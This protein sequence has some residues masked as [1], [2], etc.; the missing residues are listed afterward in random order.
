MSSFRRVD[1]ERKCATTLDACSDVF[2]KHEKTAV[3]LLHSELDRQLQRSWRDGPLAKHWQAPSDEVVSAIE[4]ASGMLT[5]RFAF[6]LT[7]P[8]S[9]SLTLAQKLGECGYRPIRA[10]PFASDDSVFV[11][12]AWDRDGELVEAGSDLTEKEV[13]D[14]T[15]QSRRTGLSPSTSQDISASEILNRRNCMSPSGRRDS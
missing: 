9:I 7:L 10:R 14:R 11:A 13:Q 5:E 3:G 6:C 8:L 12:A 2:R 4:E 15:R 1:P